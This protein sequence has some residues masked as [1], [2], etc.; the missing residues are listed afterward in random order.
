[1]ISL[2]SNILATDHIWHFFRNQSTFLI[3]SKILLLQPFFSLAGPKECEDSQ[4]KVGKM[5]SFPFFIL[6]GGVLDFALFEKSRDYTLELW[7]IFWLH[8]NC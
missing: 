6:T 5:N 2:F 7:S 1:M 3:G 8:I 4:V